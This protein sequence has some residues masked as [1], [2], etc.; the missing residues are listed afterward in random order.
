MLINID[1]LLDDI[2]CDNLIE[3]FNNNN[4]LTFNF[5]ESIVL[6]CMKLKGEQKLFVQKASML[7]HGFLTK[8]TGEVLFPDNIE[9]L[10]KKPS[11]SLHSHI[12]RKHRDFTSITYLNSL[13]S[14]HTYIEGF[15][16]I[17]PKKGRTIYFKGNKMT[18]GNRSPEKDRYTFISWYTKDI[19]KGIIINE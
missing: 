8:H 15:G 17:K 3:I 6:D 2:V 10:L 19:N 11:V 1:N 5:N 7:I 4:Q 13:D 18:H 12:D 9:I 16:D 14:G